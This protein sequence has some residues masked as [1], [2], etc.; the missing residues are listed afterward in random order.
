[1]ISTQRR[2]K[3]D[4]RGRAYPHVDT[5]TKAPHTRCRLFPAPEEDK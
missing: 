5:L 2:P 4:R 1:M 3:L